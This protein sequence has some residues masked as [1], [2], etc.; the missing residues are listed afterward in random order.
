MFIINIDE[1]CEKTQS[2]KVHVKVK[3][4][5]N[6]IINVDYISSKAESTGGRPSEIILLTKSCAN[7]LLLSSINWSRKAYITGD[8]DDIKIIKHTPPIEWKTINFIQSCLISF[9]PILQY[10]VSIYRIDLYFPDYKVAVECDEHSHKFR[11]NQDKDRQQKI[12]S[13]LNC[14]F[15]RFS[16]ET[17]DFNIADVIDKIIRTI[18]EF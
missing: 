1:I 11:K 15:I 8:F 2:Q 7:T 18:V 12:E 13:E 14:V 16:P 5:K 3:L 6:F 10:R 4:R 9:N 17:K